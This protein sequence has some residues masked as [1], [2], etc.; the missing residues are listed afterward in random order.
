M[1]HDADGQFAQFVKF[2][3]RQGLRGSDDDTLARVDAEGVEVLHVADGDAVVKAV[4]HHFIFNLLPTLEALLHEHLGREGEGF[5]GQAV[6]FLFV[7]AESR[8]ESAQ[9]VCGAENDGIAQF[10]S[11]AACAFDVLA[12]FALNRLDV[13]LVQAFHEEFAVF[14]VHDGL[15]GCAEHLQVVLFEDATL[16]EFHAAVEGGLSA[17]GQHDAIGAF[18]LDDLFHEEG[19]HGEEVDTVCH[20]LG[21]LNGGNIGVNQDG[22]NA[23]FLEG[24]ECLRTRIVKFAG[25]T[26]LERAGA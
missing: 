19:G 22:L 7:V 5:L 12:G 6:E 23:F 17:E 11:R 20:A 18:L 4:A 15:N 24:L 21:R 16:V 14:G 1:A 8:T 9:G 13:N 25:L 3:V 26:Y 10:G 2:A